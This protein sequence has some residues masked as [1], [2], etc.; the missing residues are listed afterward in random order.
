MEGMRE[1]LALDSVSY[2]YTHSPDRI[3]TIVITESTR[4]DDTNIMPPHSSCSSMES[5]MVDA[6]EI[7]HVAGRGAPIV[8]LVRTP[9]VEQYTR[10]RDDGGRSMSTLAHNSGATLN[11]LQQELEREKSNLARRQ[12]QQRQRGID[13]E[14]DDTVVVNHIPSS[15][16]GDQQDS[17]FDTFSSMC[18][19]MCGPGCYVP[20]KSALKKP[21]QGHSAIQS[22]RSV[23]FNSLTVREYDLTLGGECAA[24]DGCGCIAMFP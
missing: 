23:S 5:Q 13:Y 1:S 14:Y 10:T 15:D 2:R 3:Y 9:V 19:P 11:R 20:P 8:R 17:I 7:Q 24:G 21:G 16:S 22:K 6:I 12:E 18:L 4:R